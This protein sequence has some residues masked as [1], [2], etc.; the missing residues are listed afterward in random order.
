MAHKNKT[1]YSPYKARQ[2]K[3]RQEKKHPAK[4]QNQT[5]APQDLKG[6]HRKPNEVFSL[7]EANDRLYDVFKN[8]EF[9]LVSHEQRKQLAHYYRLLM[10]NQEKENF[11]RLLSLKDIAIKHFIDS[12]IILKHTQLSFPLM[13]LGTGP[14]LPG[15]PLKI[16][17][18]NEKILLAE[19]VQRRVNFLKH[20]REEL[21]L[22]HLEIIGKNI[23][24]D[25]VYPVY[26]VITRAVEDIS[27]TM[28]NV[29]G[30]LQVGGKIFFMKG[31]GVD[32]EIT[33]ATQEMSEFYTL[34]QDIAY[35]IPHTPNQRRLVIFKKIKSK[36]LID[37]E[38]D[39]PQENEF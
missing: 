10:L 21:Q 34:E 39:F 36:E 8:H 12:L 23:F 3:T 19:G 20:C 9:D 27:N 4:H 14:G 1:N 28:N 17:Y 6:K 29:M 32:P 26:G 25:F 13:D 24:P 18:P 7:E 35:D 38:E 11:T 5:L 31:P 16:F 2:E 33:K 22:N 37:S 15:I 30:C